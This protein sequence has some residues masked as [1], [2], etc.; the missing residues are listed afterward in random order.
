MMT[1]RFLTRCALTIAMLAPMGI[2]ADA[3]RADTAMSRISGDPDNPR[4]HFR[5]RHPAEAS[6]AELERL[7]VIVRDAL[8]RAYDAAGI[9]VVAEYQEWTR[10][11]RIPYLSKVH[12]NHYLNNYGNELAG[13]YADYPHGL[14]MPE[15]AILAKDSFSITESGEILL[16]PLAVMIKMAPGFNP[17]SG[18]WRF[19][20]IQ[21]NGV[22]LGETNGRN[23]ERVDYCIGCHM[24]KASSDH[25]FHIP[26]DAR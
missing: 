22:T 2:A 3:A 17:V 9:E 10:F 13:S 16:G 18:D 12:G 15:G 11:N 21:P 1:T 4:R 26:A 24:M 14:D 25:L 23:S 6:P 7:Y 8:A 19:L 5:L 20:Q